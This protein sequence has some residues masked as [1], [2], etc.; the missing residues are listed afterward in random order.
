MELAAERLGTTF[1]LMTATMP[2]IVDPDE[3]PEL[4]ASHPDR[5]EH[6]ARTELQPRVDDPM[7]VD[8]L[9]TEIRE[10]VHEGEDKRRIVIVNRRKTARR[11][12]R[13]LEE[14]PI[15]VGMLSTDLT[16]LDRERVIQDLGLEHPEAEDAFVLVSTQVIEA[17]VDVSSDVLIREIAPLDSIIQSAGRCNREFEL[18]PDRGRI[19]VVELQEDGRSLAVPPYSSFLI[20]STLE[21]LEASGEGGVIDEAR[22][23][24]LAR[25][26]YEILQERST[27]ASA[28]DLLGR[29]DVHKLDDPDEGFRLIEDGRPEQAHFIIQDDEEREIWQEYQAIQNLEVD[30]AED[31]REK[32]R[33][34]REIKRRFTKRIVN[35]P[36]N[37]RPEEEVIPVERE[38]G[39]YDSETGLQRNLAEDSFAFI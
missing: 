37:E 29:G 14:L 33:Q 9:A 28:I 30:S 26:Y 32:K 16:P 20:E 18:R 22:F 31:Y 35:Y 39:A 6:L 7:T 17:G 3:T 21:V 2:L 19:E 10:A 34:F 25:E 38:D 12:Y 24:E 11:L 23:H 8:E 15:P 4:L 5:Y 1:V 27:S 13:H 36:T